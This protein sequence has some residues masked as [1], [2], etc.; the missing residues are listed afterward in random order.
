M[1]EDPDGT[2]AI[3]LILTIIFMFLSAFYA[4]GASAVYSLPF[5]RVKRDAES[6]DKKAKA[7][8][9]IIEAQETVVS[10]LQ[11]GLLLCGL[12]GLAFCITVLQR[13]IAGLFPDTMQAGLRWCL[14]SLL[15]A[16]V[17]ILLFFMLCDLL[18]KKIARHWAQSF[19]YRHAKLIGRLSYA[20]MPF[21]TVTNV[22]VNGILRLLRIDPHSLDD[23]VT[24][25]E[26]LQMVGE[27]EEKGVIEETE[28]DMI[29]NILD[30]NDTAAG[31]IMTH[32]TDIAAVPDDA[33]ITQIVAVALEHGC[34]RVP[35]Y[36]E[37]I[38]SIVG[39][40]YVKDLLPYVGVTVPKVVSVTK[41]MRPAYFIPETKKCSQLF[42]EM[43][44]RKVQIAIIVDEYGGT[45]GLITLEDLME[46]I[47][48]NIQDEYD[49]EEEEIHRVSET[50]FT[51]DGTAS[52]DEI[53]DLTDIELPEGNYDTI[54]GLVTE[55]LGYIPKEGEQPQVEVAGLSIK[56]LGVEDRRL[57]RLLIIKLPHK[58]EDEGEED[59]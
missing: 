39:I 27:G 49:N 59:E 37:D 36:H 52:I 53:S 38:D 18:P 13:P 50:E 10:P 55:L 51:V 30:F 48:G 9:K 56:V 4:A 2:T 35:V 15:A 12:F 33:D 8:L 54:G 20:A 21:L 41:L 6:G 1:P 46:S 43:T 26:I 45:A 29:A 42:T 40:C 16:L 47:V 19:A 7:L 31:E 5:S 25:E 57:S 14:G 11:S 32:R 44:E 24:E 3:L 58:D 17:Y 23:A 22:I 34:S 28:K